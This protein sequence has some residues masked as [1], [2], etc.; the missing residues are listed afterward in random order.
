MATDKRGKGFILPARG[1]ISAMF[2]RYNEQMDRARLRSRAKLVK[3]SD[4]E[5]TLSDHGENAN[6]LLMVNF[7][8]SAPQVRDT[9]DDENF[10]TAPQ[11]GN[12]N[13]PI[14][15][16]DTNNQDDNSTFMHHNDSRPHLRLPA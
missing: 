16:S 12:S 8:T 11:E 15:V 9:S 4:D 2:N 1:K 10:K 7:V 3:P 13:P 5:G 14:V 6:K